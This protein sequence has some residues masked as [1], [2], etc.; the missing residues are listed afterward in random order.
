MSTFDK[1]SLDA[2][3]NAWIDAQ[4]R[5]Q[6]ASAAVQTVI[7]LSEDDPEVLWRL[8]EV[9]HSKELSRQVRDM[10]AAGRLEDL[11]VYFPDK[12][13]PKVKALA[14]RDQA[15]RAMLAGV[16]LDGNDS[17]IWREFYELAGTQPQFPP[18]WDKKE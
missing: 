16:W 5:S 12:I 4:E 18:A 10:L 9:I 11:L 1:H 3:A 8:V 15:F 17:P 7:E 13:F 2:L 6:H 14:Q